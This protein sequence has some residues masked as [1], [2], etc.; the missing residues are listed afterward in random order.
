[1]T[2]TS[3]KLKR[4]CSTCIIELEDANGVKEKFNLSPVRVKE[5]GLIMSLSEDSDI[6]SIESTN[7]F[8]TALTEIAMAILIRSFPDVEEEVLDNLLIN[9][10]QVITQ[11]ILSQFTAI[12]SEKGSNV[13]D[14][15]RLA[16]RKA[17]IGKAKE[18]E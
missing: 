14:K 10:F 5:L 9:N 11:A 8:V 12:N 17:S 1:M 3:D 2:D 13:T 18:K 4:F 7:K 6:D 16:K 15:L